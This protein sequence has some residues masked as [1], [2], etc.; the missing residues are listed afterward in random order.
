VLGLLPSSLA[1]YRQAVEFR[2]ILATPAVRWP[3]YR[4]Y[5]R[6]ALSAAGR[7]ATRR[8]QALIPRDVAFIAWIS[9]PYH[10]DFGRHQVF[11][12]DPAGLA[13]FWAHAPAAVRYVMWEYSGYSQKYGDSAHI[14][15]WHER[16]IGARA[17]AFAKALDSALKTATI[18]YRD[19][20]I[21]IARLPD[22]G[23]EG[24]E[25]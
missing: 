23:Q 11:D 4:D 7:Q 22:R 9:Q 15:G 14:H 10:L 5:N 21:V 1:R 2:S 12:G 16:L 25:R 20:R 17:L 18:I 19:E 24:E 3:A 8:L 13:T 6:R